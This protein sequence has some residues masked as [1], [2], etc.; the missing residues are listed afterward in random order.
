MVDGEL[1]KR[2]CRWGLV[3]LCDVKQS[4]RRWPVQAKARCSTLVKQSST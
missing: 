3:T 4:L 2:V 1:N